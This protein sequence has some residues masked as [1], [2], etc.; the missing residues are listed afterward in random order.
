MGPTGMPKAFM[1]LSSPSRS[2]PSCTSAVTSTMNGDR[3]R[4]TKNPGTSFTKIGVLPCFDPT[5][6][7][8]AATSGAVPACVM[9]SSN[10]IIGTGEK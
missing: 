9:I 8:D 4:F 6:I 3:H 2:T 7:A 10:G 5:S 1:A